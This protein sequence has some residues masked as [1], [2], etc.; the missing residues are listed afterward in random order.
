[1]YKGHTTFF[2]DEDNEYDKYH[3]HP[4]SISKI[5]SHQMVEF[6]QKTY[7]LPFSNGILFTIES[8]LKSPVFLLNKVSNHAKE[9]KTTNQILILSSLSSYRNI[10]SA[11]DC[12]KAIHTIIEQPN[13]DNYLICNTE[14]KKIYDMVLTI[15][16]QHNILLL[17]RREPTNLILYDTNT[18]KDVIQINSNDSENGLDKNVIDIH[19]IPKKLLKLGWKPT[20][21]ILEI[22]KEY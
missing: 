17:E 6:Y 19:G 20:K 16:K 9:W 4:Y 13:G 1:M 15:Y 12:A 10:L 3:I 14:N 2:V 21:T 18:M 7:N 5:L 11:E 22:I 8:P